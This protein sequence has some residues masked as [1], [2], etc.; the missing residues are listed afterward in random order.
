MAFKLKSLEGRLGEIVSSITAN[1]PMVLV[2]D[3]GDGTRI[4]RELGCVYI[5][6][7]GIDVYSAISCVYNEDT[8]D[9]ETDS[10]LFLFYEHDKAGTDNEIYTEWGSSLTVCV[11]N[12]ARFSGRTDLDSIDAV[13]NLDCVYRL[14]LHRLLE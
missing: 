2:Y 1:S 5:Q 8:K 3:D 14:N 7:L 11:Y 10:D 9:Y 6:D 13:E 4:W 12:Y